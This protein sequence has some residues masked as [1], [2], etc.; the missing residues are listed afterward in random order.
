[1]RQARLSPTAKMAGKLA[2]Q[3]AI[4]EVHNAL[5]NA[6]EDRPAFRSCHA[7]FKP[8]AQARLHNVPTADSADERGYRDATREC[9]DYSTVIAFH[10]S[11]L[12]FCRQK[13]RERGARSTAQSSKHEAHES[14]EQGVSSHG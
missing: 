10:F 6:W 14:H 11:A 12:F 8:D 1:M 7:R 2:V 13:C 3:N 5:R 4:F 9:R